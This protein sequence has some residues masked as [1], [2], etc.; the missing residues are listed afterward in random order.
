MNIKLN[1]MKIQEQRNLNNLNVKTSK[2]KLKCMKINLHQ[3]NEE[4][5]KLSA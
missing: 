1:L 3:E 4:L 5:T 2:Y